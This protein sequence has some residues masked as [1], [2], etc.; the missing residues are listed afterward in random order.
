MAVAG[1]PDACASVE[2][3]ERMALVAL[4]MMDETKRL[5][6]EEKITIR[7]GLHSGPVV[8]AVIGE[9]MPRFVL[10]WVCAAFGLCCVV[11]VFWC[12]WGG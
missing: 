2:A 10:L 1:A 7:I 8:G 9:T 6:L 11:C 12:V 4:R 3:A 5:S